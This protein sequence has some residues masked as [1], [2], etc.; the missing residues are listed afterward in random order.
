MTAS[1]PSPPQSRAVWLLAPLLVAV[2]AGPARLWW[3][4]RAAPD[5]LMAAG[6]PFYEAQARTLGT[7]YAAV[8]R[9]ASAMAFVDCFWM[10]GVV[11]MALIPVVFI[12]RKPPR[13]TEQPPGA[14]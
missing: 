5:K 14:H 7:V 12:M 8:L 6:Q 4:E 11:I 2:F 13:H 3:I 10:L 9:Q 1:M